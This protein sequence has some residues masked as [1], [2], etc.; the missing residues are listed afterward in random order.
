M[1]VT[2]YMARDRTQPSPLLESRQSQ[3][4]TNLTPVGM[5][6]LLARAKTVPLHMEVDVAK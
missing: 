2:L 5:A 6:E 4:L 1:F 3:Y